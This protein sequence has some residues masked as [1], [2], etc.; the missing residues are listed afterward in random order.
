MVPQTSKQEWRELPKVFT[1]LLTAVDSIEL[2]PGNHD[3]NLRRMIPQ[4]LTKVHF[5]P[6]GGA[7]L[8]GLGLFHGHTWPTA[9]V[10]S[11]NQVIMAHNHPNVLFID[12]LGGRASYSCWL[13]GRLDMERAL[14]RY[15]KIADNNDNDPE[16]IIM[17][18]FNDIG[19]GTPVNASK[20]EF[21]GPL[22]KNHYVDFES[23]HVYLLD[24]TDLGKLRELIN[25]SS[26]SK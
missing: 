15:P 7:V 20:P 11:A 22:L 9:E 19:S 21:L 18:A 5:H 23:A 26:I 12:K 25:L 24:G 2:F 13:R 3:G 16:V 4:D 10:M 17:P 1:R 8:H 14:E 6:T